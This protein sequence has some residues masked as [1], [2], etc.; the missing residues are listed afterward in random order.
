MFDTGKTRV[1][2]YCMVKKTVTMC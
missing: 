1:I 2:G